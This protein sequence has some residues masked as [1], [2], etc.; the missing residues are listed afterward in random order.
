MKVRDTTENVSLR[1]LRF[2]PCEI[3]LNM[4]KPK[5][6]GKLEILKFYEF[7]DVWFNLTWRGFN[8]ISRKLCPTSHWSEI[9]HS[10]TLIFV[11]TTLLFIREIS[12][13]CLSIASL[14]LWDTGPIGTLELIRSTSQLSWNTITIKLITNCCLHR[15][16][17]TFTKPWSLFEDLLSQ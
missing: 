8:L 15:T 16:W 3:R 12:T 9:L 4:R 13:V 14:S 17:V 5:K 11:L 1:E 10:F 6:L 2:N 7:S